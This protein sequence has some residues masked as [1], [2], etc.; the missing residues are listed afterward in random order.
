MKVSRR[1][2]G[3]YP[4]NLQG[5]RVSQ[6]RNQQEKVCASSLL[7]AGLLLGLLLTLKMEAMLLRNIG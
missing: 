4:L 2:G 5:R 1:F 3:I 7:H 6:V